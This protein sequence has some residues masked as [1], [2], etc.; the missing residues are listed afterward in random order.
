LHA[1]A[2]DVGAESRLVIVPGAEHV[3]LGADID[4][5]WQVV[6][7]FLREVFAL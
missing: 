6:T 5:Q 1:A 2:Q 4:Q 3:F 7:D